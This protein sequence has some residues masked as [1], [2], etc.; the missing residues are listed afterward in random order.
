M[1]GLIADKGRGFFKC[2][3]PNIF[4]QNL[5]F[6]ES[7]YVFTSSRREGW[8]QCGHGGRGNLSWDEVC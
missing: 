1:G 4:A 5:R 8:R 6:F 2:R 7:C 3:S